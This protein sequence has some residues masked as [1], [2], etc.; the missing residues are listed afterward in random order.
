MSYQPRKT[1]RHE[2][3]SIRGLKHRLTWWGEAGGS[4][5]VL[6]HGFLDCGATWQFLVDQ[7]PDDW[8][9]VAPDWRGFGGSE[10]APG[11]Y[12][13]PDYLADLEAL[14]DALTPHGR[15]RVI[16]HSMGANIATL[17]SGVRPQR[18]QWL[19]NLEGLGLP[20]TSA[21]MAPT[22][23]AKWL[24]ELRH[25]GRAGRYRSVAQLAAI[26]QQ[27]NP[28]LDA[29]HALFVASCWSRSAAE[30]ESGTQV[31]LAFDPAHRLVNPVLYRLEEA[32]ACWTR[33]V[34]PI[35][36]ITGAESAHG[37]RWR[38]EG[39]E[40]RFRALFRDLRIVTLP[41]VGHM[42]HHEDPAAVAGPIVE[43]ERMHA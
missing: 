8:S 6:L 25:P 36:L 24:D 32:E 4:P 21:D 22:R 9:L 30:D 35:L 12:W 15:A 20:R 26:L 39:V 33:A 37:L 23:Y 38:E 27:R 11:G 31:R 3:L 10:W 14:L 28:R 1:P 41:G 43:F 19:V 16:G 40:E 5:I 34:I 7:L 42:M 17:Y 18:L 2:D 29:D 13:F